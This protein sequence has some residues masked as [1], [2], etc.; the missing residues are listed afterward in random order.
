MSELPPKRAKVTTADEIVSPGGGIEGDGAESDRA[1][2]GLAHEDVLAAATRVKGVVTETP[3]LTCGQ[4]DEMAGRALFFKCENLQKGGAFKF[5]GAVNAVKC[6]DPD[7]K[8]VVT[9]SSGNH[10]QAL[11][12]AAKMQGIAAHIIMPDNAPVVKRAA[13]VGYG[14][15]VITCQS[16]Q[17]AREAAANKERDETPGAVLIPPYN[18]LNV[19][20][21]QGTMALEMV[22]QLS[23]NL[24]A[25]IVP[26]GGGGMLS[27]VCM[28]LKGAAPNVRIF[29]AEP[30]RADD[31]ARSVAAGERIL[32]DAYPD[33]V[34][35]GLRTSM[36]DLTWPVIRDHVEK[37]FTVTEDEIVAAMRLVWERM[38]L[39]IEPSAGV[40]V[41]VAISAAFK[42]A[43]GDDCKRVGV[44]LCGGNQDLDKIPWVV[45]YSG[46]G[47][48]AKREKQK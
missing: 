48:D 2:Y 9:H 40:S 25:I 20:A 10:A 38:K 33:T 24:D 31:C 14:A 43:V 36:G 44:I 37:V 35:D 21:G 41:A 39:V 5:R 7:C 23:G 11:A 19:M 22:A 45:G 27:G 17:E 16:T 47:E 42:A 15:K 3:V 26:I 8:D 1:K 32:L 4:L 29:A 6:L 34:A 13:V 28:A 46:K 18:H 12:L 30:T